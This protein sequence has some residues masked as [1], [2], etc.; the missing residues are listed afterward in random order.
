[1]NVAHQDA[2]Q[3]WPALVANAF[4]ADFHNIAWSGAGVV[5]NAGAGCS[6]DAPFHDLY[7]RML[8]SSPTL[9]EIDEIQHQIRIIRNQ[10]KSADKPDE[11]DNMTSNV[12][13]LRTCADFVRP[14]MALDVL[15]DV[16]P[17]T[18][19]IDAEWQPDAVVL[20][21]GGNDWWSLA[22]KGLSRHIVFLNVISRRHGTPGE[23]PLI[24]G[25]A[26]FLQ[27]LREHRGRSDSALRNRL[28]SWSLTFRYI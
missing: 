26:R 24:A 13:F 5:W 23:E 19:S 20:Y 27:H 2:N 4:G 22:H 7:S 25:F 15:L 10:Y 11:Y 8:G 1:M 21:L 12:T 14:L 18:T 3:A 6:A 16:L 9:D 17:R 28:E